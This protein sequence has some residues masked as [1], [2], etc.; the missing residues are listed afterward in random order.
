MPVSFCSPHAEGTKPI[1][2]FGWAPHASAHACGIVKHWYVRTF[3][4]VSCGLHA[5]AFLIRRLVGIAHVADMDCIADPD[6][7]SQC[8]RRALHFGRRLLVQ[9]A[10]F[11]SI[12]SLVDEA[13][14]VARH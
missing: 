7:R 9:G 13:A 11:Q 5:G 6:L 10:T 14:N 2:S 3:I 1:S 12:D 4:C 8:E